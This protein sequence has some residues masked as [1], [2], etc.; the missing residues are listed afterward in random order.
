MALLTF[1]TFIY[2]KLGQGC[3]SEN[4]PYLCHFLAFRCMEQEE[5]TKQRK[6]YVYINETQLTSFMQQS[7]REATCALS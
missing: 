3:P 4:T 6:N 5:E 2:W 7:P 1:R